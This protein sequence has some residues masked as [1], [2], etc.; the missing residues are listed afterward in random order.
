[1]IITSGRSVLCTVRDF[2]VVRNCL[3]AILVEQLF[4]SP[5]LS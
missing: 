4:P 2:V 3:K 1:M 5:S